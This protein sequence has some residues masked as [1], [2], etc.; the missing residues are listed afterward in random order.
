MND[1]IASFRHCAQT[2]LLQ[3]WPGLELRLGLR[4][5]LRRARGQDKENAPAGFPAGATL[6]WQTASL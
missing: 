6:F 4:L 1:A 5:G 3:A 2:Y